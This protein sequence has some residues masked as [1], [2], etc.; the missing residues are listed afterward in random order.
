[1]SSTSSATASWSLSSGSSASSRSWETTVTS[2]LSTA[3]A[4][5]P[6]LLT[7]ENNAGGIAPLIDVYALTDEPYK[8]L[9]SGKLSSA[10]KPLGVPL[11]RSSR[12]PCV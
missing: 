1:M 8:S 6:Q 12:P 3:P 10:S 4:R 11:R 9:E 5:L 7:Y 2:A